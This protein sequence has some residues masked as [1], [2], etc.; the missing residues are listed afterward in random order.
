M[1]GTAWGSDS[2]FRGRFYWGHE[3]D[4]F[5][6]CGSKKAYWVKGEERSLRSL[7]DR[8]EQLRERRG[9][10]RIIRKVHHD[11]TAVLAH[12]DVRA[13]LADAGL[14]IVANSPEEFY[15]RIRDEIPR[16]GRVIRASG[17]RAD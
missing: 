6:P 7:R 11:T 15:A 3:V 4:S 13:K 9:L 12:P 17:A 1:A 2:T 10:R 14:E 16:K 8:T 5:R